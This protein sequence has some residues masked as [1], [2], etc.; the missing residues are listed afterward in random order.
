MRRARVLVLRLRSLFR[1]QQ[2]DRE[3]DAELRFHLEREIEEN[4]A[5][6]MTAEEARFAAMRALGSKAQLAE[7][8]RDTRRVMPLLDLAR[9]GRYALR[10]LAR[11]RLF[12][13]VAIATLAVGIGATTAIF[14]VVNGVLLQPLPYPQA[15][16]I[17]SLGTRMTDTGREFP[18]LTGGDLPDLRAMTN[19]FDSFSPYWG[20]EIGV[21]TAGTGQF[22]GVYFVDASFFQAFA[23][24]AAAGRTFTRGDGEQAAV[25]GHGFASRVFGS[26]D[27]ALGKTLNVEDQP[28]EV[29]GVLPAG[30]AAPDSTDVW[31]PLP[32]LS[33][34]LR[35]RTAF[36][37]HAVAR[38]A[39]GVSLEQ[40]Q[41]QVAGLGTRLA[42][43]Y[44]DSNRNRTFSVV[45]WRDRL[46]AGSRS[47][48][49]LLLGAVAL[50]L[51]IACVNVANLLLAR[52]TTRSHEMALRAALGAGRWRIVRQLAAESLVLAVV[53]G[54]LG[55]ALAYA[56]TDALVRLAPDNLPRLN[57]VR[58]DWRVL[59]FAGGCS[60]VASL[61]FGLAPAWQAS[62]VDP[63]GGL[64]GAGSRGTVGGRSVRLRALLVVGEIALSFALAVGGG[65]LFRSFVA[66]TRSDLGFRPGS[67]L[68][69]TA[70]RPA[71][72]QQEY[73][74]VA[75]FFSGIAAE[76]SSL[77]G[78]Q[79]VGATMGLPTGQY[80][81]NGSYWVEGRTPTGFGQR[82]PHAVFGLA[83][84]GYF[85]ALGVPLVKGRDFTNADAFDSPFVAIINDALARETFPG[86]DPIGRRV[87]CG[88]DAPDTWMTIVGVV[89]TVRQDSPASPREPQL[90]MPLQQHPYH[91][92]EV[93]VVLRTGGPPSSLV[94]AVRARMRQL[95]PDTALK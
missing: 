88:L 54:G 94:P 60:L 55:V 29:V 43:A 74:R 57:E 80:G 19:V 30:F 17:V 12:A 79:A 91:A 22:A 7:E 31:L 27:G 9:D 92:N 11:N 1:Q 39:P 95:T 49:Y 58:I 73:V 50:V 6:G 56:G 8:C 34:V 47:T 84:P 24:T 51:L 37:F 14:S 38:L 32:P 53:A 83:G 76:F 90:Y 25:V 18:R 68:V 46:V 78:V 82:L 20:G 13:V 72:R 15:D 5:R 59:A 70:H 48:L 36:N 16:R 62:R 67:V 40:A 66:L 89:G 69:V 42:R 26:A 52:A 71:N 65:L 93:Q 23:V 28:Y 3:L 64:H 63:Q 35:N 61:L 86:E 41:A 10:V 45:L 85:A 75:R 4:I 77:P 87:R 44:P 81:S 33:P 21:Q 2:A